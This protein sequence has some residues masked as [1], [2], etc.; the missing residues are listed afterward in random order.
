MN[1]MQRY[2]L[3]KRKKG[4]CGM[5]GCQQKAEEG[6]T[7]CTDCREENRLRSKKQW[8]DKRRQ[9]LDHYGRKCECCGETEEAFLHLDHDWKGPLG[10]GTNRNLTDEVIRAGFPAYVRIL[11]ANCNFAIRFGRICPHQASRQIPHS[12]KRTG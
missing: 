8:E 5:S 7:T 6:K 11:C 1:P 4:L 12:E 10:P 2:Y 9:V 3:N